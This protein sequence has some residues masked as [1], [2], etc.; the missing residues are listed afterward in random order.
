MSEKKKKGGNRKQV[1]P[2]VF[3]LFL[4]FFIFYFFFAIKTKHEKIR[5]KKKSA[6]RNLN[7]FLAFFFL[8]KKMF[9]NPLIFAIVSEIQFMSCTSLLDFIF[10]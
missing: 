8:K 10:M 2:F 4:F 3:I 5:V 6:F 1:D 9:T 7:C